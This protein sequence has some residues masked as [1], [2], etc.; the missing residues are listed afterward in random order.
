[1]LCYVF[2]DCVSFQNEIVSNWTN[3]FDA[4]QL[5]KCWRSNGWVKYQWPLKCVLPLTIGTGLSALGKPMQMCWHI[6][7]CFIELAYFEVPVI[8]KEF[9]DHYRVG[10]CNKGLFINTFSCSKRKTK[11][12]VCLGILL[13][14]FQLL[15]SFKLAE[16]VHLRAT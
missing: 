15:T 2:S 8:V 6:L 12:D 1:M 5:G 13:A 10:K 11:N 3:L 16:T 9:F 7:S 14:Y 4:Q